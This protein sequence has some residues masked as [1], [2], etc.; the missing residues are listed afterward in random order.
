M[1]VGF[2]ASAYLITEDTT[3]A[4]YSYCSY[5]VNLDN[6]KEMQKQ[7]DGII[8]IHKAAIIDPEKQK[9]YGSSLISVG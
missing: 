3:I 2:G 6:W 8:R 5:N 9:K 7:D 1:S 4:I